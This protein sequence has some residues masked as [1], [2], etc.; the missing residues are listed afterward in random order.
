MSPLLAQFW[1][2]S[3][4]L[5]VSTGHAR[6]PAP[7]WSAKPLAT[8]SF[9]SEEG[10]QSLERVLRAYAAFDEEVNYCQVL[11]CNPPLFPA[12][13]PISQWWLISVHIRSVQCITKQEVLSRGSVAMASSDRPSC[14]FTT[15]SSFWSSEVVG[16]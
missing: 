11:P 4:F 14:K 13:G 12:Y 10:K 16:S 5:H 15:S 2:S 9:T 7:A 6:L 8:C 1:A 3:H